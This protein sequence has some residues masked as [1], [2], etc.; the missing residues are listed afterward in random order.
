MPIYEYSCKSCGAKF[1]KLVSIKSKTDDIAC[2]ICGEKNAEKSISL[3]GLGSSA[4]SSVTGLSTSSSC[5]P[6]G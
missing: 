3:F 5:A 4:S 2:P 1:E 6:S